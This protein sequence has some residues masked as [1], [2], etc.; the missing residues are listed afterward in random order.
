MKNGMYI[1][2]LLIDEDIEWLAAV[3]G[4]LA[5]KSGDDVVRQGC[6]SASIY[7]V[8]SGEL[9]VTV[10]NSNGNGVREI[11]RVGPGEVLGEISLIDSRPASATVTARQDSALMEIPKSQLTA[12]LA[13]DDGFAA[14]FYRAMAMFLAQRIRNLT[15]PALP[16]DSNSLSAD[17]A[18]PDELSSEMLDDLAVAGLRL[19]RLFGKFA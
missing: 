6:E 16:K 7:L 14:R 9:A 5:V 17:V 8:T 13:M 10:P 2:G 1:L 4:R 15:I 19:D 18:D 11:S 12:K 3:S